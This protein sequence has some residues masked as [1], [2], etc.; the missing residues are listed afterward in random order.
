M[1]PDYQVASLYCKIQDRELLSKTSGKDGMY[2]AANAENH[3]N[4][5]QSLDQEKQDPDDPDTFK[6]YDH[7]FIQFF[8]LKIN[9]SGR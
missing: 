2:I 1:Q 7:L 4:P 8:N 3:G 5:D 9:T 6:P